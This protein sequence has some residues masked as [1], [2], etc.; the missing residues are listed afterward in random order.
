MYIARD[1]DGDLLAYSA[2]PV[3]N[4][5]LGAWRGVCGYDEDGEYVEDEDTPVSWVRLSGD[6]FPEVTWE[7]G[8]VEIKTTAGEG[9][10]AGGNMLAEKTR[11]RGVVAE[12][13]MGSQQNITVPADNS[14]F[15]KS[16]AE[17]D[18]C[19]DCEAALNDRTV[20]T[21]CPIG[22]IK[23]GMTVEELY[24]KQK[25]EM[26]ENKRDREEQARLSMLEK[27]GNS[28]PGLVS[29]RRWSSQN[30]DFSGL[31]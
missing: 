6:E 16:I 19:K 3:R 21:R 13:D 11:D 26:E 31:Q 30:L 29:A 9:K 14:W 10:P 15:Y 12:N 7:T 23:S 2:K 28:A 20:C 17:D 18:P 24:Y 5:A 4:N 27:V 22:D 1:K 25:A 8:A